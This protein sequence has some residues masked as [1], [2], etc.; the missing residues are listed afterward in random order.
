M[1]LA[2]AGAVKS[3]P[4]IVAAAGRAGPC[5]QAVHR[6]LAGG[7]FGSTGRCRQTLAWRFLE[8]F[9]APVVWLFITGEVVVVVSGNRRCL[10][11]FE[12]WIDQR[13]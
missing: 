13:L 3:P 9:W 12:Y 8:G 1:A 6:Q 4:V 5:L 7:V 10:H 11:M 2:S